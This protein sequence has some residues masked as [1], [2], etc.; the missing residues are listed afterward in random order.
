MAD[1]HP[2]Y[3]MPI[4]GV[5]AWT[6][7]ISPNGVGFDIACGNKAVLTDLDAQLLRPDLP[8]VMDEINKRI[9]FGMGRRNNEPVDH[10]VL[11]AIREASF[12][13][14]RALLAS[15]ADQLGTVGGGNHY[16]D[17]LEDEAGRV[18]V[19]VHFGSRGF[20][21][22]TAT[23]FLALAQG[24]AFGEH[25]AEGGMDTGPVLL[26][27]E[28]ELGQGYV[29]AMQ[30]AGDYAYAGRDIVVDKVL[31][32]L[33]ARSQLEVHNHH[34]FAWRER[35]QGRDV[36]VVRKGA[37]P[38]F[39]GQLG[40][41]GGSM[42]TFCVILEGVE[43]PE[44]AD[45]LYSTVH[46][47]GRVMSRTEAAGKSRRRWACSARD[48]DWVQPPKTHKPPTCPTCGGTRFSKRWVQERPGRVDWPTVRAELAARGIEL[49]GGGADEAPEVYK[50]LHEV[51]A[52][53]GGTI[54]VRHRLTPLGVAMAGPEV[55]DP[56]KD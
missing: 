16:V 48:C 52:A 45:A 42:G 37:T 53:Q 33:G 34:N 35:H 14:Q 23:G 25:A 40:F 29:E 2:G 20:G 44:S 12:E 51:L 10:P 30:L 11:D 36:W 15:A 24:K 31:E 43:A 28:T 50:D 56:Y 18:W 17:L 9:S 54:R 46:G 27:T 22:K 1:H 6:D 39:P 55:A 38:A 26:D 3:G 41:V 13:P 7:K 19:G 4:G 21:H 47:A 49:R 8:R 5:A 32:I